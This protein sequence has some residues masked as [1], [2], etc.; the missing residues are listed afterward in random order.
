MHL[1]TFSFNFSFASGWLPGESEKW[2]FQSSQGDPT[3]VKMFQGKCAYADRLYFAAQEGCTLAM[4]WITN[5]NFTSSEEKFFIGKSS[6]GGTLFPLT[7]PEQ[8]RKKIPTLI[9]RMGIVT[10]YIS[11]TKYFKLL[12]TILKYQDVSYTIKNGKF[13]LELSWKSSAHSWEQRDSVIHHLPTQE[14]SCTTQ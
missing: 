10:V 13:L 6:F 3:I 11:V 7:Q 14:Q 2:G 4:A 12:E 8:M 1:F 5:S 9:R